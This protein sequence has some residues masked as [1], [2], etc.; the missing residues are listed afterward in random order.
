MRDDDKGSNEDHEQER[1]LENDED[2]IIIC[3]EYVYDDNRGTQGLII[4]HGKG[5]H[6]DDGCDKKLG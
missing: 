5:L 1:K 2:S 6:N 4:D 3:D